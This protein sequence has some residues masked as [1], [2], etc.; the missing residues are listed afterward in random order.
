MKRSPT[1][2]SVGFLCGTTDYA[3]ETTLSVFGDVDLLG[4]A[5]L[6]R[7][8]TVALTRSRRLLLDL[9]GVRFI[10]VVGLNALL[11]L[12]RRGARLGCEVVLR[13]A[14]RTL[15]RMLAVLGGPE[16]T[17]TIADRRAVEGP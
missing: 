8:S 1:S 5:E 6:V 13:G 17:L 12:E 7:R 16:T 11:T 3:G 4:S 10:D 2:A 15:R 14:P 9:R